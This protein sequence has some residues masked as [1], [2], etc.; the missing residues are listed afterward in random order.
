MSS[1]SDALIEKQ[2]TK[3]L[4]ELS[5]RYEKEDSFTAVYNKN[6]KQ[7]Y[8]NLD[9]F[10]EEI[11]ETT[12]VQ[13][14]EENI[15]EFKEY[16]KKEPNCS[17]WISPARKTTDFEI[18]NDSIGSK[19]K[20]QTNKYRDVIIDAAYKELVSQFTMD[21]YAK[22][23]FQT[24]SYYDMKEATKNEP[25]ALTYTYVSS[26][27]L[28]KFNQECE[29]KK[30]PYAFDINCEYGNSS[31]GRYPIVYLRKD[32][33]QVNEILVNATNKALEQEKH[34]I[35]YYQKANISN[36]EKEKESKSKKKLFDFSM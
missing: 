16:M 24:V 18:E 32:Y 8:K 27:N 30:I 9:K 23:G 33:N 28:Y 29:K 36:L 12:K 13:V 31:D 25:D 4:K 7:E 3:Y 15:Q 2:Y 1:S 6:R 21:Y 14:P 19:V 10:M 26:K 34:R 22:C 5:K 17:Y 35:D 20:T 11:K